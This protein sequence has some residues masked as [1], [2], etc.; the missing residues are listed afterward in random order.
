MKWMS[1]VK[2]ALPVLGA[3]F[4]PLT[5]LAGAKLGAVTFTNL[6]FAIIYIAISWAVLFTAMVI[7]SDRLRES[8]EGI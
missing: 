2:W 1:N 7:Y 8:T 3:I 5:Y 6:N 4:G